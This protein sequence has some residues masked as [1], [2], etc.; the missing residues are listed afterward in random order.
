VC[1]EGILL[2]VV[3]NRSRAPFAMSTE[4]PLALRSR[5]ETPATKGVAMDVPERTAKPPRSRGIV[6]TMLPPGAATAGLK[7]KLFDGP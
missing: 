6:E 3:S 4:T 1:E 2:D 5:A 7:W